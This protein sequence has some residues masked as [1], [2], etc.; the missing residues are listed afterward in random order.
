MLISFLGG[1]HII[2]ILFVILIPIILVIWVLST[3]KYQKIKKIISYCFLVLLLMSLLGQI[4]TPRQKNIEGIIITV[5]LIIVFWLLPSYVNKKNKKL[6]IVEPIKPNSPTELD[7]LQNKLNEI[8][9]NTSLLIKSHSRG[10]F[11]VDEF[12]TKLNRLEREKEEVD[13]EIL[14]YNSLINISHKIEELELLKTRNLIDDKEFLIKKEEALS[15]EI[16][17]LKNNL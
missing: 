11:D 4:I 12:Q 15:I 13:H 8:E 1:F 17:R 14:R 6:D 5:V 7:S 16:E 9:R 2:I 3:S 10:L